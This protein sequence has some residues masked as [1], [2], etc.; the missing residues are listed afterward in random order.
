LKNSRDIDVAGH[1]PA[2][3]C[4]IHEFLAL[5]TKPWTLHILWALR[6]GGPT[7]FGALRNKVEGISARVLTARLRSL[8]LTGLVFR[9][10]EP[11][12]PPAVSYGI[13]ERMQDIERV[14][15]ELESLAR[16]WQAEDRPRKT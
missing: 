16:K 10:Y 2:A 13:T 6:A 8:E 15:Q 1:N 3:L 9:H 4:P 7:R 11:T 5:L 14:F 12:I